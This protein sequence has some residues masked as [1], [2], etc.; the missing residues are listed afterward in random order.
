MKRCS[1]FVFGFTGELSPKKTEDSQRRRPR[2]DSRIG[3]KNSND[4]LR[5]LM[6]ATVDE[7]LCVAKRSHGLVKMQG[8]TSR[9]TIAINKVEEVHVK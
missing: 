9:T 4:M 1:S 6:V 5:E 3:D 7:A 8:N 2:T